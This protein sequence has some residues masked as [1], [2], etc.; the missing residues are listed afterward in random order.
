MNEPTTRHLALEFYGCDTA[1]LVDKEYIS[2]VLQNAGAA[3]KMAVTDVSQVSR[4]EGKTDTIITTILMSEG[5]IVCRTWP[6]HNYASL[7]IAAFGPISPLSVVYLLEASFCP[8][9]IERMLIYRG[10]GEM[11]VIRHPRK[12]RHAA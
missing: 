7:T 1:A 4:E 11:S 10:E 6:E 12:S 8:D 5:S 3:L 2:S 9:E